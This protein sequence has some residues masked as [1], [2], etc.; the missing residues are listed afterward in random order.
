MT[1]VT[2][3]IELLVGIACVA[4]AWPCWRRGGAVFR[5]VAV[6]L[7]L[8]GLTAIANAIVSF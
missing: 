7:A 2:A 8:A 1:A 5:V 4:L 3:T 6:V